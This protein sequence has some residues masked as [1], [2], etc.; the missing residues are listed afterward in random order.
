[1]LDKMPQERRLFFAF[2]EQ[3]GGRLGEHIAFTWGDAD[4]EGSRILAADN[5]TRRTSATDW[6]NETG[7]YGCLFR[8][9][10]VVSVWSRG[11]PEWGSPCSEAG[12][13]HPMGM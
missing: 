11:G 4:I 12:G 8:R 1:M 2:L 6:V 5:P 10:G 7:T 3:D 9:A 13:Y